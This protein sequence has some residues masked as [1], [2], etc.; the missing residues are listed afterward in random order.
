MKINAQGLHFK[1]LNQMIRSAPDSSIVIDGCCGQRYIA[2]GLSGKQI[3]IFGTPGNAL[4]SYLDGCELF[5]HGDAQDAAGDTMN[6]GCIA[7]DGLAGDAAGYAMRGGSIYVHGDIGYRAGIHMKQY[8]DKK[9]LLVAGGCAG[10]FLGEYQA[11]GTIIILGLNSG[12]AVPTGNFCGMGMHGG[13]I[14]LRCENPPKRIAD[15][16]V[17]TRADTKDL[18]EI[19]PALDRFCELF[20]ESRAAI[21][22]LPFYVITPDSSNPYKQ[23][24]TSC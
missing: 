23:L 7:I 9:P 20:G 13:K 4:G 15:R 19:A 3:E 2:S 17:C 5:V 6:S 11:G 14:F 8:K 18:E 22:A 16:L 10:S 24:Y 1:Q 21:D 12:G